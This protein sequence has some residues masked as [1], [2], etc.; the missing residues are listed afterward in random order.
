MAKVISLDESNP[1]AFIF[2]GIICRFIEKNNEYEEYFKKAILLAQ[3]HSQRELEIRAYYTLAV[4]FYNR[5]LFEK[6]FDYLNKIP[7]THAEALELK[8]KLYAKHN[9]EDL[10][11]LLVESLLD[12]PNLQ[13]LKM[14]G[15]HFIKS[16]D[17][18]SPV[19]FILI[20]ICY[21]YAELGS[22]KPFINKWMN[23]FRDHFHEVI[24]VLPKLLKQ[25]NY[26]LRVLGFFILFCITCRNKEFNQ[27]IA[28]LDACMKENFMGR[29]AIGLKAMYLINAHRIQEAEETVK[30]LDKP[31]SFIEL[32]IKAHLNLLKNDIEAA[33]ELSTKSFKDKNTKHDQ[34]ADIYF[35]QNGKHPAEHGNIFYAI[36][37]YLHL[38][39]AIR[40][41]QISV[42][43][44]KALAT[45]AENDFYISLN[46]FL[47]KPFYFASAS[48]S[49]MFI[50]CI[51]DIL[52]A[53][54]KQK[55]LLPVWQVLTPILDSLTENEKNDYFIKLAYSLYAFG[56]I[57]DAL[58][59]LQFPEEKL[60][61][62][63]AKK[64]F[65]C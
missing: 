46:K 26:P 29:D 61:P 18:E 1:D 7:N 55:L 43:D 59:L 32:H 11:V 41:N 23:D 4:D 27:C 21:S 28:F 19:F 33:W 30:K 39:C 17:S 12:K 50:V 34:W 45:K 3:T 8:A 16:A 54:D 60:S 47:N 10:A 64:F 40:G 2:A 36:A 14:I 57:E 51:W 56:K 31:F 5:D 62:R 48:S 25:I 9:R 49:Y 53:K 35:R 42:A 20:Y 58:T 24:L 13:Q 44:L 37:R 65:N 38:H 52:L 22:E 6:A 63:I 15:D